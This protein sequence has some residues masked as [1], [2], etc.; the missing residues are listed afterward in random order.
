MKRFL[1]L[2]LLIPNLLTA[3]EH[4]AQFVVWKLKPGAGSSFTWGYKKHL[5]WHRANNDTWSWYAWFFVSGPRVDQF[6]DATIDHPW[7]DFDH[8]V[9]PAED[10][11]DVDGHVEPFGD[12][13]TIEKLS[14]IAS[15]TTADRADWQSKYLRW[16]TIDVT[17][18]AEA[19]KLLGQWERAHPDGKRSVLETVDGGKLKQLHLLLFYP[20]MTSYGTG[21][22][23]IHELETLENGR[24]P[25]FGAMTSETLVYQP[26]MSWVH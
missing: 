14:G 4:I 17:N 9:K 5:D 13:Q 26:G 19:I 18:A 21:M 16:I 10:G 23:T 2:S 12:V 20:D 22:E 15:L 1:I 25:V 3:Q 24:D 8:S 6:I 7:S 11:P